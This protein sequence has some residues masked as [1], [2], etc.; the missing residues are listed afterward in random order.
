MHRWFI[1]EMHDVG[2][3]I[4]RVEVGV[5]MVY[6]N[7]PTWETTHVKP[8]KSNIYIYIYIYQKNIDYVVSWKIIV[9]I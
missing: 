4:P 2:Q 3:S 6:C 1:I 5:T 8:W 9:R 7:P